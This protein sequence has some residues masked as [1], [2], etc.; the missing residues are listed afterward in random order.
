VIFEHIGDAYLKLNRLSEAVASWQKAL[1]LDPKN[2]NLANKIER[3]KG[4]MGNGQPPK[5]NPTQ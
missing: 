5:T 3:T 4:P 2:K 1:T